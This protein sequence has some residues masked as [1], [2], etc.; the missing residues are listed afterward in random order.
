MSEVEKYKKLKNK[1]MRKL[2]ADEIYKT[3]I[4]EDSPMQ[5]KRLQIF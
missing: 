5:V 4:L 1:N 2:K 3:Y